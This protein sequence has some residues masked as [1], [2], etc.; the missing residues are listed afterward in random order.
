MIR[1]VIIS[2]GFVT[3][4]PTP[5]ANAPMIASERSVD[6]SKSMSGELRM[7]DLISSKIASS[8]SF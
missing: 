7:N 5:P 6:E 8:E 1:V 3:N 4:A 2:K